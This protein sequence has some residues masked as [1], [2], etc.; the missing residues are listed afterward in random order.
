MSKP[1]HKSKTRSCPVLALL[2]TMLALWELGPCGVRKS[3]RG[4]KP[5]YC[6]GETL[7]LT[8]VLFSPGARTPELRT[9][10]QRSTYLNVA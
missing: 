10:K 1:L 5:L 3:G 6:G 2:Q 8:R 9:A 4:L 7:F